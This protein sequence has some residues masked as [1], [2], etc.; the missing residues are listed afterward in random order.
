MK[1]LK[2]TTA[3]RDS[4]NDNKLLKPDDVIEVSNARAKDFADYSEDITEE[5]K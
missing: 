5:D 1:T 2:I 4:K 3:V